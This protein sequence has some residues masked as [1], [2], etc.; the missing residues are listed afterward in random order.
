MRRIVTLGVFACLLLSLMPFL[1]QVSD[2]DIGDNEIV[3]NDKIIPDSELT[4]PQV[5][6]L[7]SIDMGRSTNS[8]WST[9]G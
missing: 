2:V 1:S 3:L 7:N 4:L 8:T 6:A 9:T 5:E